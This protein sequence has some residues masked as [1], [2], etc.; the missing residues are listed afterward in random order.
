V[1]GRDV[2]L[3]L[4]SRISRSAA[5][6]VLAVV[7]GLYYLNDLH[8][9][10]LA[11][12][13]LFGTGA[14]VTPVL[15]LVLGVFSDR[16]GRKK[17][18]LL[19]LFFLPAAILILLLTT[20]FPLL[21]LSSAL[22]G[23]GIAGGL[24]GGGVGATAAPM[25][26]ALLSEKVKPEE[27]TKVFSIFTML[28]SYAG[29]GG[30]LLSHISNYRELFMISLAIS[31]LS[32]LVVIPVKEDFKPREKVEVSKGGDE[33]VIR[34]FTVTGVLNGVSQG[35]IVPFIPIIFAKEYGLTQSTIGEVISLGGVMSA[36]LMLA[37]PWLASRMGFVKLIIVTRSA[38]AVMVLLF[39]F[40]GN[41]LLASLDY[42]LFTPLRVVSLPAQQALMMNLVGEGRRATATGANQAGRLLPSAASTTLSGFLLNALS[43]A[44]PFEISCV[45]T[46]ANSVLYYKF[47]RNIDRM[48]SGNVTIVE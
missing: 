24:I 9:S 41:T 31:S 14:F 29:A 8:L 1:Y 20:S 3:L 35:L 23:F 13:I 39:P 7:V 32:A 18:L 2:L 15:S 37:T 21:L 44:L 40:L 22:G 19:T 17:V 11:I 27:R 47:F 34:K 6:G 46:L 43:V 25:Q 38:S 26:T 33:E 5:A 48:A 28:S 10:L 16:I 12:G 42:L 36:T 30:A 45:A 4:V